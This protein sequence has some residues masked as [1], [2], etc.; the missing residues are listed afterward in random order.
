MHKWLAIITAL[1]EEFK[2]FVKTDVRGFSKLNT[3]FNS[4]PEVIVEMFSIWHQ[5]K[6]EVFTMNTQLVL[7]LFNFND[8]STSKF[9]FRLNATWTVLLSE[10]PAK[11]VLSL[12]NNIKI[13]GYPYV[14]LVW[15]SAGKDFKILFSCFFNERKRLFA[16]GN[17]F[18]R[19]IK[20]MHI[21]H[22]EQFIQS[23]P[24]E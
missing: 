4:V 2:N 3:N 9:K 6:T 5:I 12:V 15:K 20:N 8:Q 11:K 19:I 17:Y 10:N 1:L 14:S 18:L 22:L 23:D 16:M 21:C 13:R 24:W 7:L